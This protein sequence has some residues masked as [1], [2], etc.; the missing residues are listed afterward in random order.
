[1]W[2]SGT[3]I[4]DTTLYFWWYLVRYVSAISWTSVCG[5]Y[6]TYRSC[7]YVVLVPILI[8]PTGTSILL[9]DHTCWANRTGSYR[10]LFWYQVLVGPTVDLLPVVGPNG[11]GAAISASSTSTTRYILVTL[12]WYYRYQVPYHGRSYDLPA[13]LL[14]L[15]PSTGTGLLGVPGTTR[16]AISRPGQLPLSVALGYQYLLP[17]TWYLLPEPG[18]GTI[19]PILVGPSA[20]GRSYSTVTA[21]RTYW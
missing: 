19:T 17:V 14:G 7:Y 3:L 1:M 4:M 12:P 18:T 10:H 16:W 15:V 20:T 11:T 13:L 6:R 8:G 21:G 9:V 5:S 2:K